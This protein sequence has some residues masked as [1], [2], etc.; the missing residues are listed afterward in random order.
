VLEALP[1]PDT[2]RPLSVLDAGCG[3]G[4]FG[5]FLEARLDPGF[6]YTGIDSSARLLEHARSR[7][8][9]TRGR[10]ELH[11]IDLLHETLSSRLPES[12]F[13]LVAAFGLT[14]HLPGLDR[15]RTLLH[16][17]AQLVAPKGLLAIAFWQFADE[18]RFR[19]RMVDWQSF[20]ARDAEPVELDQLEPG[21]H[22]LNWGTR[23]NVVR[24]CHHSDDREI[25]LLISDIG[26][27]STTSFRS[28]A[29]I[30]RLNAYRLLRRP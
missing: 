7:L 25:E 2:E 4:R 30:D 18:Q 24:Y 15:R 21:D 29:E 27:E 9:A 19:R 8:S 12:R 22:L 28:A 16:D 17:L 3:N 13:D 26:L 5:R 10:R 14:H 1:L 20:N 23:S 6:D 11:E